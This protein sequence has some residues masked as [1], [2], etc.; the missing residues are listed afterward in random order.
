MA[1]LIV[2]SNR[3]SI[4]A[5]GDDRRAGGLEVALREVLRKHA[6]AWFGW[7][8][9]VVSAGETTTT[10]L[11]VD[12]RSYITTDLTEEDFEEYYNGFANR[13][14]WP[15]LH[16][17]MDLAE[18]SRRD[19]TGF[20]RVNDYFAQEIHKIIEPD[21]L[22]WVH[23]YHLIPLAKALRERGHANRIGFFLHTPLPPA[24]I[25][26]ALPRHER[27]FPALAHYDLIGFQTETD[28][29]NFARY[30][31]TE[32]KLPSRDLRT[33]LFNGRSLQLSVFPVGVNT[34][35]FGQWA[36]RG[37]RSAFARRVSG[38]LSGREM[39][40][41]VDRLDYSKGIVSRMEAF[42]RLLIASPEWRNRVT[43]LQITPRSRS[44]IREYIEMDQLVSATAGR[45]NGRHGEADWTPIRYVN[46]TYA[47]SA[48]AG[49][50]RRARAGLV[51]PLRDGMNLV[52]KEY[53]VAQNPDDPGVLV[54]SRFAGAAAE[55]EGAI[56]VNPYDIDAVAEALAFALTMPLEERKKRHAASMRRLRSNDIRDWGDRFLE[57]LAVADQE[58]SLFANLPQS[59]LPRMASDRPIATARA[60]SHSLT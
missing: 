7:S 41:G 19:L 43:Y 6:G 54:L 46:R 33:F 37:Q 10:Q 16:Y 38:S 25:L 17:R 56:L 32:C 55:C 20:L 47:R 42:E 23:D 57:A 34:E 9:H 60:G 49:L 29:S 40:I 13:V 3:V 52:A 11:E 24:E 2:V 22:V 35:E 39:I 50:Y 36:E 18:Y 26:T 30:L 12:G 28:C 1:R 48:L 21:D 58:M 14:L 8:G 31:A 27:F 15:I 51:T 59:S 45:I 44:R 5:R 53:I 4:P